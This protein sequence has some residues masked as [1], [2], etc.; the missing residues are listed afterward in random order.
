MAVWRAVESPQDVCLEATQLFHLHHLFSRLKP[1]M[2]GLRLVSSLGG[3]S[4]FHSLIEVPK[5]LRWMYFCAV[6]L[7]KNSVLGCWSLWIHRWLSCGGVVQK[8]LIE[9]SASPSQK[10]A[11]KDFRLLEISRSHYWLTCVCIVTSARSYS[12]VGLR[13]SSQSRE[14][15]FLCE[16]N[17]RV[18][19]DRGVDGVL[20]G[21][22]ALVLV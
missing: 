22:S 18:T 6:L 12:S 16:V 20:F 2:A 10:C 13:N 9:R 14:G 15:R 7:E 3:M 21:A 19:L 17:G 1:S 8:S 4:R 5:E 11:R